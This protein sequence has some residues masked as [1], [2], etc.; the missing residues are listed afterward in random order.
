L[1]EGHTAPRQVE[2]DVEAAQ[3]VGSEQSIQQPGQGVHDLD[4]PNPNSPARHFDAADRQVPQ[5]QFAGRNVAGDPVH[6][7]SQSDA[8]VL[9]ADPLRGAGVNTV[10]SEPVSRRRRTAALS[11]KTLTIGWLLS[12][13][14]AVSGRRMV[15]QTPSPTAA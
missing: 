1:V 5:L 11:A 3:D 15:P 10:A 9:R 14:T 13:A 4:R 8:G 6:L 12:I 7:S 2:I